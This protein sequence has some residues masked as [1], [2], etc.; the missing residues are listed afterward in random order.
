MAKKIPSD[1]M[2]RCEDCAASEF[3]PGEV[4]GECHLLPMDWVPM[5][6]DHVRPMWKAAIVGGWCMHFKRKVH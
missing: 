6:E 4:M 3:E 2:P 1:C 5:G